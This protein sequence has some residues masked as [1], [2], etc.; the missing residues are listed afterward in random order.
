M[1]FD[2][3]NTFAADFGEKL[4][5]DKE[6]KLKIED[7]ITDEIEYKPRLKKSKKFKVSRDNGV[8]VNFEHSM[9]AMIV[10]GVNKGRQV[11]ASTL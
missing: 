5:I 10:S 1:S 2:F 3:A 7:E 6:K 4:K 11:E 8:D 9:D